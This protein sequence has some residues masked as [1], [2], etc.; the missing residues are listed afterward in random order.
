MKEDKICIACG[1]RK[2]L[3]EFYK[4]KQM[5]DGHLGKCKDCCKRQS[6]ERESLLRNDPKWV[7]KEKIRSREKY[8][9]LNYKEKQKEWDKNKPWKNTSVYKNLN[10]DLRVNGFVEKD[11]KIHHW[12]YNNEYLKDVFILSEKLH[13]KLHS[14]LVF[15]I[16]KLIFIYDGEVLDSKEKHASCINKIKEFNNIDDEVRVFKV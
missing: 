11:E 10:R 5:S 16:D 4:H 15:D 2:P 13:R 12:N 1:I 8:D 9:R 3:E 7:E 14:F 6:N